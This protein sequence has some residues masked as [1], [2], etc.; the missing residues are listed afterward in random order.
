[1]PENTYN[2]S[3]REDLTEY[4]VVD[5]LNLN[6]GRILSY[7]DTNPLKACALAYLQDNRH[8]L[9]TWNY[10][11]MLVSGNMLVITCGGVQHMTSF[12]ENDL[13]FRVG[14]YGAFK[15][16][17]PIFSQKLSPGATEFT[18]S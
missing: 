11:T 4:R 16:G 13:L 8:D 14:N 1:M 10:G 2:I 7:F 18:L 9:N 6:T 5:V 3:D 15:D 17:R 12:S